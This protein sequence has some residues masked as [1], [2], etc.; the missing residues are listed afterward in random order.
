MYVAVAV[1]FSLLK[2]NYSVMVSRYCSVFSVITML[3]SHRTFKSQILMSA[4]RGQT[5][6]S[7]NVSTPMVLTSV[8]VEPGTD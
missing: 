6:V 3:S 5:D 1:G 7:K 2:M 4:V 8:L